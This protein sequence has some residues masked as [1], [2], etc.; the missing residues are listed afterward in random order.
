MKCDIPFTPAICPCLCLPGRGEPLTSEPISKLC[1][2]HLLPWLVQFST[3]LTLLLHLCSRGYAIQRICGTAEVS[4]GSLQK[5]GSRTCLSG[6]GLPWQD[7]LED[8]QAHFRC[9]APSAYHQTIFHSSFSLTMSRSRC[10][11]VALASLVSLPWQ[12]RP[13]NPLSLIISKPTRRLG[14]TT[15][16]CIDCGAKTRQTSMQ[17]GVM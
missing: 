9:R 16:C 10:G 2:R 15:S 12:S 1:V 7:A 5:Q 3:H 17:I 13:R 4:H 8:Q 6:S 11:I 14:Q